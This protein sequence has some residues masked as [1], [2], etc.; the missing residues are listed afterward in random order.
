MIDDE[1]AKV[2]S[3]RKL[4]HLQLALHGDVEDHRRSPW[5]DVR[6]I[7][8]ALPEIDVDDVDLRVSFMGYPLQIP[9]WITGMT[10][11]HD[12]AASINRRLAYSAEKY[13]LAMGVG[14]QRAGLAVSDLMQT[15]AAARDAAPGAVLIANIGAPQ[16]LRQGRVPGLG[17]ADLQELVRS[18]DAQGLAIHLNYLQEFVQP[19]GDRRARG[20]LEAIHQAVETVNVPVMVKETG[21]GISREVAV[22]L[23]R[24]GISAIDVA[25]RGGTSMVKIE[26]AR[27][28]QHENGHVS[29]ASAFEDW[30]IS[31]PAAVMECRD[32]GVPL[33]ATGGIRTGVDAA[34]AFALGASAAGVG[35]P[36]L[37]AA[38]ESAE[39]LDQA[40]ERFRKELLGALFLTG[41]RTISDLQS[42]GAMLTGE[43]LSWK[44]QRGL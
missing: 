43:L 7:H 31:T 32:C 16:L 36:F 41:S 20:V 38:A 44:E 26:G 37:R 12:L 1:H 3:E 4:E 28:G 39:E 13:G 19:E 33:V 17:P 24:T 6:L 40:V 27:S 29:V 34:R 8:Q 11:G 21:A 9:L 25:G 15:Y 14:S 10:G 5:L 23:A 18:I 42:K 30:G 22:Q 35:L 2:I